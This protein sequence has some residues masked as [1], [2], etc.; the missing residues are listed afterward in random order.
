[1][2][3]VQRVAAAWKNVVSEMT[4]AERCKSASGKAAREGLQAHR[5]QSAVPAGKTFE[6]GVGART[7]KVLENAVEGRNPD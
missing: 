2:A 4:L 7:G 6:V 5:Q 1:M 3:W